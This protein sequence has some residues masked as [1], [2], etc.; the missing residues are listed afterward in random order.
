MHDKGI[1][2]IKKI[3]HNIYGES[4]LIGFNDGIIKLWVSKEI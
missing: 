2:C 4:L 1:V 3:Y